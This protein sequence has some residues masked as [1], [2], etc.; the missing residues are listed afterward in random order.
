MKDNNILLADMD[1][2]SVE[3][4]QS[5]RG[6]K[7]IE[8]PKSRPRELF[9]FEEGLFSQMNSNGAS[10]NGIIGFVMSWFNK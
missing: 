7:S 10:E 1:L 9:D 5:I 6:G 2:L 4:M 3:E 8:R